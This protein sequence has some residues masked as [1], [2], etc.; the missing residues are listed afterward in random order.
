MSLTI[1]HKLQS[2]NSYA[3]KNR[4]QVMANGSKVKQLGTL[5]TSQKIM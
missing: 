2:M 5:C 3:G 1:A 4:K